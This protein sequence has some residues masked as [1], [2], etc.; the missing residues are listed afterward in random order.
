MIDY[1]RE[2]L[3]ARFP[4]ANL[5]AGAGAVKHEHVVFWQD[6]PD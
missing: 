6:I 2:I 3:A 1:R 4:S 5:M